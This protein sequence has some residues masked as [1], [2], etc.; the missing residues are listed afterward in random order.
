[1]IKKETWKTLDAV[2]LIKCWEQAWS[3]LC[4]H[5]SMLIHNSYT[6]SDITQREKIKIRGIRETFVHSTPIKNSRDWMQGTADKPHF[7]WAACASRPAG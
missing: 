2:T 1:M 3:S 4:Y 5:S 6:I 7:R